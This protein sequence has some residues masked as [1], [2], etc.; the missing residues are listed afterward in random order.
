MYVEILFCG[1]YSSQGQ[2]NIINDNENIKS[3]LILEVSSLT[4][5]SPKLFERSTIVSN[6]CF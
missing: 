1:F 5:S 6:N 3:E 2:M 4:N